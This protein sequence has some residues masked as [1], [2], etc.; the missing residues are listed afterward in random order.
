MHLIRKQILILARHKT[1]VADFATLAEA[2]PE[3][4]KVEFGGPAQGDPA[5]WRDQLI[6]LVNRARLNREQLGMHLV[7]G[8][9]HFKKDRVWLRLKKSVAKA[10]GYRSRRSIE[11]LMKDAERARGLRKASADRYHALVRC[12]V[13]AAE[14]RWAKL[15]ELLCLNIPENE[16]AE[17]A[18][19]KVEELYRKVIPSPR[20][21][22]QKRR[23]S[24][25]SVRR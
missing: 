5:T 19:L 22:P 7:D 6:D 18:R 12:G 3:L 14:T 10:A 11:T 23:D 21:D 4:E 13:D 17:N 24:L 20:G 2:F 1:K 8:R 9:Q 25:G 16:S 15:I